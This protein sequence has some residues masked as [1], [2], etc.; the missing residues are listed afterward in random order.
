[1]NMNMNTK[2]ASHIIERMKPDRTKNILT[3]IYCLCF[4]SIT[5]VLIVSCV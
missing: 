5:C 3:T 2:T 4:M 1:M